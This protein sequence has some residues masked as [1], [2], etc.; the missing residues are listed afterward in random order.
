MP[1]PSVRFL[2]DLDVLTLGVV[3]GHLRLTVPP[4]PDLTGV[5]KGYL[6]LTVPSGSDSAVLSAT[7]GHED[8]WV[9]DRVPDGRES[10]RTTTHTPGKGCVPG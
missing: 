2:D 9:P 10:V 1:T 4:G 3:K 6:R 5:V 7:D 8:T